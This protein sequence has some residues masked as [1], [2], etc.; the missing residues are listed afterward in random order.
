M[1]LGAPQARALIHCNTLFG[2]LWFL[3]S[4]NFSGA[5]MF[6]LSICQHPRWKQVVVCPA[7]PR[8]HLGAHS[9][10]PGAEQSPG[11]GHHWPWRSPAG[12]EA[13][14]KSSIRMDRL[15]ESF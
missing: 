2:V 11:E 4:L 13:L 14:K 3:E 12:E 6:L 15:G 1:I 5:T 8:A 7:Q 10:V 9:A